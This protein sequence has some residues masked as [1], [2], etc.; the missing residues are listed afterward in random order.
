MTSAAHALPEENINT[1]L[2]TYVTGLLCARKQI[3]ATSLFTAELDAFGRLL[4]SPSS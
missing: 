3:I 4:F 1:Q 2:V